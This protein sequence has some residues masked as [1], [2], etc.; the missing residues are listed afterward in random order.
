VFGERRREVR[1]RL[2]LVRFG[3]GER[4]IGPWEERLA[5]IMLLLVIAAALLLAAVGVALFLGWAVAS[6]VLPRPWRLN[7]G[8]AFDLD[9]SVRAECPTCRGPLA[10]GSVDKQGRAML[11]DQG[12]QVAVPTQSAAC[13]QCRRAFQRFSC[14]KVWSGWREAPDAAP[15]TSLG[16]DAPMK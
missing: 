8:T 16:D 12:Q 3:G 1:M 7:W 11:A 6:P 14:G 10:L 2:P 13:P 9:A 5:P 4:P 15:G